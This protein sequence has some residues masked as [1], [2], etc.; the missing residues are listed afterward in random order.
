MAF[1]TTLTT[2]GKQ[3]LASAFTG[4]PLVFSK[5]NFGS[6]TAEVSEI[7]ALENIK[8]EKAKIGRAHV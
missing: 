2:K 4:K 1:V 6:G 8:D 3:M 5:V 7:P